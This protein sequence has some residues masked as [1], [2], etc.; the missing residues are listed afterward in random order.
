M[1]VHRNFI[2]KYTIL[3]ILIILYYNCSDLC[4][5]TVD[6]FLKS[7]FCMLFPCVVRVRSE[8]WLIA[9]WVLGKALRKEGGVSPYA[10][11]LQSSVEIPWGY[12]WSG[13]IDIGFLFSFLNHLVSSRVNLAK[14]LCHVFTSIL[15]L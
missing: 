5:I 3:N 6:W 14:E 13:L 9:Q 15:N 2:G 8:G 10:R 4:M 12:F 1:L 11:S 7:L